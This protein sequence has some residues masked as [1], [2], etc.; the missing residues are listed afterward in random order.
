[1]LKRLEHLV[2]LKIFKFRHKSFNS[3]EWLKR[4]DVDPYIEKAKKNNYRLA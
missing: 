2:K 1:M 3:F 4:R